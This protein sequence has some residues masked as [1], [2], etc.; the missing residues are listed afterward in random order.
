MSEVRHLVVEAAEQGLLPAPEPWQA[1]WTGEGCPPATAGWWVRKH[2]EVHWVLQA[3][4]ERP[5]M[6]TVAITDVAIPRYLV[7]T[8]EWLE[9]WWKDA[10]AR[11]RHCSMG[12]GADRSIFRV[13]AGSNPPIHWF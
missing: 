7:F 10:D 6:A 12:A 5:G 13:L 3:E 11:W 4:L 1:A 9:M 8:G 2:D